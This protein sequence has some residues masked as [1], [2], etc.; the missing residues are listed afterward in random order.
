V[1]VSVTR[2]VFRFDELSQDAQARAVEVLRDQAWECLDSEMITEDLSLR[3]AWAAAKDES[4]PYSRKQL[5]AKYGI[6]ISW[7]VSYS[8][9]DYAAITGT[10][11][12]ADT[13]YL[14]W[15]EGVCRISLKD[16]RASSW[17]EYVVVYDEHGDEGDW[18][19]HGPR[20]DAACD[21]ISNLNGELYRWARQTCEDY[22]ATAYVVDQHQYSGVPYQW[23]EDGTQAP[24]MFWREA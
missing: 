22:T 20:Y 4:G 10:L 24:A 16:G 9:S 5:A 17:P 18:E 21:M 1:D 7:S 13:P 3:F 8:Q 19:W 14:S 2:T 12:R 11:H 23:N 6:G 15:P